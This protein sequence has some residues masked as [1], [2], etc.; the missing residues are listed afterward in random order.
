M[1]SAKDRSKF[2][3]I[4]LAVSFHMYLYRTSR[5]LPSTI[6]YISSQRSA[7]TARQNKTELCASECKWKF[8]NVA[9]TLLGRMI[10]SRVVHKQEPHAKRIITVVCHL[11]R[12]WIRN[13]INLHLILLCFKYTF[14]NNLIF[15]YTYLFIFKR[16]RAIQILLNFS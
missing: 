16:F 2:L 4:F 14:L 10:Y 9:F 8:G 3:Q 6:L 12:N 7:S 5:F 11:E 13:I 15:S 1:W